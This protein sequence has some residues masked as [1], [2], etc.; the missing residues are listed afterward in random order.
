M[1]VPTTKRLRLSSTI[2]S[3]MKGMER[4]KSQMRL[5]MKFTGL[6]CRMPPF[7]VVNRSTP[8]GMPSTRE[9]TPEIETI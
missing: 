6:F 3:R 5:R 4:K 2:A 8:K 9:M 7:L 1:A